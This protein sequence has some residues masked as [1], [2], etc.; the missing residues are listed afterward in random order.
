M[1][2]AGKS[3]SEDLLQLCE[4][5]IGK[6][7]GTLEDLVNGWN[8]IRDKRGLTGRWLYE[9]NT[10]RG[11]FKE[12]GCPLVRSGLIELHPIQCYCSQGMMEAVFSQ[13]CKTPIEVEL[14]G[15][16]ARGDD[17]CHFV[18]KLRFVANISQRSCYILNEVKDTV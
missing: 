14:K 9:G 8:T 2:R 1:K 3:C 10:L 16:I 13:V 4:K 12:C 7:V 17:A 11:V 18:V 5:Y 15:T 6:E